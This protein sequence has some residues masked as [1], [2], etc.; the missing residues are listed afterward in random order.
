MLE[1]VAPVCSLYEVDTEL[2]PNFED[3]NSSSAI[4]AVEGCNAA[5][6]ANITA[7]ATA[8]PPA[9]ARRAFGGT[10]AQLFRAAAAVGGV[11]RGRLHTRSA[12]HCLDLC[13]QWIASCDTV[14]VGECA[15]P[16]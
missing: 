6:V 15:A 14:A 12:E 16:A 3:R 1:G 10:S 9:E 11:L 4:T 7:A 5:A 2:C 13:A 8:V